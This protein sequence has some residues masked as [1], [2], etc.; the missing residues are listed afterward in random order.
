MLLYKKQ[1]VRRMVIRTALFIGLSTVLITAAKTGLQAS[2]IP[3]IYY[4]GERCVGVDTEFGP[5]PCSSAQGGAYTKVLA[6]PGLTYTE[7]AKRW[8]TLYRP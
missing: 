3:Q 1:R 4:D 8:R 5:R 2:P 6:E 7:F